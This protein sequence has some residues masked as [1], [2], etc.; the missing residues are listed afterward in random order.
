MNAHSGTGWGSGKSRPE[1][2]A[3]PTGGPV[4]SE[5]GCRGPGVWFAGPP[6]PR[7]TRSILAPRAQ[8]AHHRA[9]RPLPGAELHRPLASGHRADP[10]ARPQRRDHGRGGPASAPRG[11]GRRGPRNRARPGSRDSLRPAFTA[12]RHRGARAGPSCQGGG[13][14]ARGRR[15]RR[16]ASPRGPVRVGP[17]SRRAAVRARAV[18]TIGCPVR[19]RDWSAPGSGHRGDGRRGR[20]HRRARSVARE[21]RAPRA[22]GQARPHLSPARRRRGRARGRPGGAPG[23]RIRWPLARRRRVPGL[24]GRRS[25]ADRG[26]RGVRGLAGSPG[27]P[28]LRG[29]P[30]APLVRAGPRVGGGASRQRAPQ[31][32]HPRLR[33]RL[34]HHR[35]PRRPGDRV[36]RLR[37]PPFR[38]TPGPRSS[39][40]TSW[41]GSCGPRTG[42]V[43]V[44]CCGSSWRRGTSST[45]AAAARRRRCAP[46]ARLFPWRSRCSRPGSRA[47]C[48]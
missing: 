20:Q 23:G 19:L 6:F 10:R 5:P 4:K 42:R 26:L 31:D 48:C 15:Q 16:P 43:C 13:P 30:P 35:R 39:A 41:T 34:H 27:R 36:Q 45:W 40:A 33:A 9:G 28:R 38:A 37:P 14:P 8:T 47:R 24:P 21:P 22:R 18:A 7:I 2:A 3:T 11:P 17:P 1:L 29:G 25:G 44:A 12:H 46:T 32:D